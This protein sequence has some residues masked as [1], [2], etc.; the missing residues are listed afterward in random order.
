MTVQSSALN[1]RPSSYISKI[2]VTLGSAQAACWLGSGNRWH[3]ASIAYSEMA[4]S[5]RFELFF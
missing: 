2:C 4:R 5:E 3:V 1:L